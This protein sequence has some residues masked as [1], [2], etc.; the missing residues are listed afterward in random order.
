MRKK[1][2]KVAD[3]SENG[4]VVNLLQNVLKRKHMYFDETLYEIYR[5]FHEKGT[6]SYLY[7]LEIDR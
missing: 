3:M 7:A 6:H 5:G 2:L 4:D 1:H